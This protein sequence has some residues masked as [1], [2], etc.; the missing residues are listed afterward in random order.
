MNY[1]KEDY[2]RFHLAFN[3]AIQIFQN[4]KRILTNDE[5]GIIWD[6]FEI[7]ERQ[8]T[9][10]PKVDITSILKDES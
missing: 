10:N 1:N 8:Y 9:I 5:C 4:K 7:L 6:F 2:L 3:E